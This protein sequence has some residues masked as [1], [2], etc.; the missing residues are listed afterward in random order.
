MGLG[1]WGLGFRSLGLG[2][3]IG[4]LG[5]GVYRFMDGCFKAGGLSNA[6]L[7]VTVIHVEHIVPAVKQRNPGLDKYA[8]GHFEGTWG[9][10][11]VT[12]SGCHR[13]STS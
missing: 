11:K 8:Q 13:M 7:K 4:G 12:P 1:V 2:I 3:R 6:H 10:S 5:F 9:L